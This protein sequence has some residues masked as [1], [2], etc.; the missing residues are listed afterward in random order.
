MTILWT[1]VFLDND[2]SEKR[3]SVVENS[4]G[5]Y[6]MIEQRDESLINEDMTTNVSKRFEYL[7]RS[8][9]AHSV[10]SLLA[11]SYQ[12][13]GIF[14]VGT[15]LLYRHQVSRVNKVVQLYGGY[16]V[17]MTFIYRTDVTGKICSGDYLTNE[18][19]K[20]PIIAKHYLLETGGLYWAYL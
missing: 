19:K 18:M 3:C 2:L 11:A 13:I 12:L 10:L 20:D 9:L 8:Y 15:L 14:C 5:T 16:I 17:I 6:K 7:S 1:N 4:D